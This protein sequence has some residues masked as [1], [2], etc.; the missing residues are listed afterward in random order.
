MAKEACLALE[1]FISINSSVDFCAVSCPSAFYQSSAFYSVRFHKRV[2]KN[3]D[4]LFARHKHKVV[5]H[6]FSPAGDDFLVCM[7]NSTSCEVLAVNDNLAGNPCEISKNLNI[8]RIELDLYYTKLLAANSNKQ[9]R[10]ILDSECVR[11]K[12]LSSTKSKL[13]TSPKEANISKFSLDLLNHIRSYLTAKEILQSRLVSKQWKNIKTVKMKIRFKHFGYLPEHARDTFGKVTYLS[14]PAFTTKEESEKFTNLL[15]YC[16]PTLRALRLFGQTMAAEEMDFIC[17]KLD[18]LEILR[19]RTNDWL[20]ALILKKVENIHEIVVDTRH[21]LKN[22]KVDLSSREK[23]RHFKVSPVGRQKLNFVHGEKCNLEVVTLDHIPS[24]M[25]TM[26]SG[27]LDIKSLKTLRITS[28]YNFDT[29]QLVPF[30]NVGKTVHVKLIIA[31]NR[32]LEHSWFKITKDH[33]QILSLDQWDS[34]VQGVQEFV[35][36]SKETRKYVLQFIKN[37]K[38]ST[39]A[40]LTCPK[41]TPPSRRRF[42]LDIISRLE[43]ITYED[44]LNVAQSVETDV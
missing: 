37:L 29:Y 19:L 34:K 32:F 15:Q 3:F 16:A 26:P 31:P 7:E 18:A 44:I 23:L 30:L 22:L 42:I 21:H 5:L 24:N 39:R 43:G 36:L 8:N 1:E 41:S 28:S 14:M 6:F 12:K 9:L 17:P 25:R 2:K 35:R 20:A 40:T 38:E 27:L 11:S 4:A 10:T 13:E 33:F